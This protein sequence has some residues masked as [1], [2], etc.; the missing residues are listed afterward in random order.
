MQAHFL[1]RQLA[2]QF[3]MQTPYGDDDWEIPVELTFEKLY[4]RVQFLK[5]RLDRQCKIRMHV[6]CCSLLQCER[7]ERR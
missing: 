7:E 4:M 5:H 1:K 3:A 6:E 2:A